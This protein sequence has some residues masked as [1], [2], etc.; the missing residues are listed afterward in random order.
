MFYEWLSRVL[1]VK[2]LK[3][4]GA[5]GILGMVIVGTAGLNSEWVSEWEVIKRSVQAFSYLGLMSFIA[6]MSVEEY[7]EYRTAVALRGFI[8]EAPF[9]AV[10]GR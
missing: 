4:S 1:P 2:E 9:M 10:N 6:L 3:I 5:V 7:V 8:A